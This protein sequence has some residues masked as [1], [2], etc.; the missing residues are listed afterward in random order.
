MKTKA[1][2]QRLSK[3][4]EKLSH[5]KKKKRRK[6]SSSHSKKQKRERLRGTA[7]GL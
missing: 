2:T 1:K 6:S 5:K 4:N 3:E 7:P